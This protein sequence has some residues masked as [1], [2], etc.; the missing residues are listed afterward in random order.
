VT[1]DLT[2]A[3]RWKVHDE[4][5][6]M[7]QSTVHVVCGHAFEVDAAH[8]QVELLRVKRGWCGG[9]SCTAGAAGGEGGAK[10][11]TKQLIDK[12]PRIVDPAY[13][14]GAELLTHLCS[15]STASRISVVP[16]P[17]TYRYCRNLPPRV[18]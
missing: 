16:R 8:D 14:T 4:A 5:V 10:L 1:S 13:W 9:E 18:L 2:R 6:I 15:S 17:H 12:T 7:D 3:V 11:A